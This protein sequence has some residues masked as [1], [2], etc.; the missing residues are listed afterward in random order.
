MSN[1][2]KWFLEERTE[3][4][5]EIYL[6]RRD[7]LTVIRQGL[8]LGT[9]LLV[10]VQ[11]DGHDVGRYFGVMLKGLM[12]QISGVNIDARW[13][14]APAVRDIPFPLCLFVFVMEGDQG[15]WKWI[16]EPAVQAR[17]SELIFNTDT[18]LRRLDNTEPPKT[19]ELTKIISAV[20][21]WYDSRRALVVA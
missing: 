19:E 20:N 17:R 10:S 13:V 5:A 15:Y 8:P 2:P 6:T 14:N 9:D 18:T 12:N 1:I 11:Q 16:Q 7:D 21:A 3:R 4:L